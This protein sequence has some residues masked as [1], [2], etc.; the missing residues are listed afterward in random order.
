MFEEVFD[1]IKLLGGFDRYSLGG[2][3]LSDNVIDYVVLIWDR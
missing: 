2:R 1:K 3:M